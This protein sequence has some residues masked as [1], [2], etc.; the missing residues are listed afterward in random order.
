M[1]GTCHVTGSLQVE[2]NPEMRRRVEDLVGSENFQV[3]PS[4]HNNRAGG[5]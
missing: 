4:K 5:R 1:A 3:V 2:I